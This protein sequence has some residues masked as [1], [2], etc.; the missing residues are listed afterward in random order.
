MGDREISFLIGTTVLS[1]DTCWVNTLVLTPGEL[2]FCPSKFFLSL[3]VSDIEIKSNPGDFCDG[4]GISLPPAVFFPHRL[5]VESLSRILGDLR[6]IELV[7]PPL[8]PRHFC[9]IPCYTS[10]FSSPCSS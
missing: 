1:K 3:G 8:P 9:R 10:E 4:P 7:N 5:S 2:E 6:G